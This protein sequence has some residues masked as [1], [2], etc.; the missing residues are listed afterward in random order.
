MDTPKYR[1]FGMLVALLFV[2]SIGYFSLT[3][4]GIT[5]FVT[6]TGQLNIDNST[7][8][9][10]YIYINDSEC[11]DSPPG[12]TVNP[13]Q[14]STSN[15]ALKATITDLNGDCN[16]EITANAYLCEGTGTCNSANAEHT[17]SLSFDSQ[18]GSGNRYCNYTANLHIYH[19]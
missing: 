3:S 9:V 14:N 8:V 6:K 12:P 16:S 1:F 5:G 17:I 4:P 10:N 11:A 19:L 18:W 2:L 7:P 15:I 13:T